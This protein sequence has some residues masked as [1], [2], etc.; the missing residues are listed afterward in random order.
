MGVDRA[1]SRTILI[2]IWALAFALFLCA[3]L[4]SGC[5]VMA[6]KVNETVFYVDGAPR[7]QSLAIQKVNQLAQE[8]GFRDDTQRRIAGLQPFFASNIVSSYILHPSES[9]PYLLTVEMR[10]IDTAFFWDDEFSNLEPL[11]TRLRQPPEHD[12]VSAYI[13]SELSFSTA[14]V[15]SNYAGGSDPQLGHA[16][17]SDL[18][19]IT[20]R[21]ET[22]YSS[23]RFD[24]VKLSSETSLLLSRKPTCYYDN[25]W[26]N[27]MLIEDAYPSL[28]SHK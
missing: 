6:P 18:D 11:A 8:Q 5:R 1:V 20:D 2:K 27:R 22:I 15:L 19:R 4:L 12:E 16:L 14:S 26:L 7:T 3:P 25:R 9:A 28:L 23:Q 10:G 17:A 13:R 24:N 21:N